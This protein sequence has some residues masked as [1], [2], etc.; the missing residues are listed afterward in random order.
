VVALEGLGWLDAHPDDD[1]DGD[2]VLPDAGRA[3]AFARLGV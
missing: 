2:P 3:E 1:L